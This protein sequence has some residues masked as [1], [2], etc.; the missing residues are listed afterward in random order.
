MGV[1]GMDMEG[2][3]SRVSRVLDG[4]GGGVGASLEFVEEV[5]VALE[6]VSLGREYVA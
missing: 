5:G 4:R 3:T 1:R 6:P 2:S